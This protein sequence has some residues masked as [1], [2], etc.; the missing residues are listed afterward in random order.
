MKILS[1]ITCF[2]GCAMLYCSTRVF[3]LL[4]EETSGKVVWGRIGDGNAGLKIC[5]TNFL[6]LC[7]PGIT[8]KRFG[9]IS[10]HHF[11]WFSG[12]EGGRGGVGRSERRVGARALEILD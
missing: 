8:Y 10:R 3:T 9:A 11:S 12:S 2:H 7:W 1:M 6:A 4:G 5:R